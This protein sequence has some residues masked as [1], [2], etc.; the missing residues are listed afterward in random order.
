VLLFYP[1]VPSALASA[2]IAPPLLELAH[3]LTPKRSSGPLGLSRD[4]FAD[5]KRSSTFNYD[6]V[7]ESKVLDRPYGLETIITNMAP[8]MRRQLLDRS[9]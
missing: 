7:S 6:R 2:L 4:Y 5:N 1:I 9:E 3:R 8:L